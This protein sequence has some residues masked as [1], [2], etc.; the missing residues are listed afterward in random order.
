MLSTRHR[1]SERDDLPEVPDVK[2]VIDWK[3]MFRVLFMFECD[4]G[5]KISL[6]DRL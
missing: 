3:S 2:V 5:V 6:S 1:V 4:K